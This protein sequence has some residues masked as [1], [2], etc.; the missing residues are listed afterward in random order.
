MKLTIFIAT[1]LCVFAENNFFDLNEDNYIEVFREFYETPDTALPL[2]VNMLVGECTKGV[3]PEY[4]RDS[5]QV[6]KIVKKQNRVTTI[7]CAHQG[8]V[9]AALPKFKENNQ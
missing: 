1:I 9:C 3:C 5:N 8:K 7:D 2:L 4:Y 6:A